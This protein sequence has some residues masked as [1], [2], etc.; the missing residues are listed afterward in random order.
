MHHWEMRLV[1]LPYLSRFYSEV[2]LVLIAV[3]LFILS[4]LLEVGSRWVRVRPVAAV[5]AAPTQSLS[6]SCVSRRVWAARWATAA[7]LSA[8]RLRDRAALTWRRSTLASSLIHQMLWRGR[9]GDLL[10]DAQLS[11]FC[12]SYSISPDDRGDV[13]QSLTV[14]SISDL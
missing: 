6:I 8:W 5:P 9:W 1:F 13:L 3:V 10:T 2:F 14:D 11:S 4:L 7:T 12:L